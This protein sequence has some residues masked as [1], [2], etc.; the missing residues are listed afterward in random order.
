MK[1]YIL[2]IISLLVFETIHAQK[3][4]TYHVNT[5]T[6]NVRAEPSIKA[7]IIDKISLND[8]VIIVND[9]IPK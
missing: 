1:S 6:L 4:N 3:G 7:E 2:I 9:S 5:N 8:N